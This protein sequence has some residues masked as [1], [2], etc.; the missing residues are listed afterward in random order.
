VQGDRS[1]PTPAGHARHE[2]PPWPRVQSR[3]QP[4]GLLTVRRRRLTAC[5][6]PPVGAVQH[7]FAWFYVYGAVEP[8][9][10]ARFF[11]ARPDL[12]ADMFQR[13]IETFAQA[14]AD[15]LKI[16]LVDTRGAHTAQ[17]LTLPD[18]VPL[19]C[20]PPYGPE[21]NPI[22]RGWRDLKETLA[23]LHWAKLETQQDDMATLLRGYEAATRPTLTDYTYLVEAV[24]ALYP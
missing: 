13:F 11:L 24:H 17:R 9:T 4:C 15:S 7:R 21:R 23:W 22:A 5:G 20:V 3:R 8:T 14:F 6:V 18:H 2:Y 19:V 16:L 10:G 1:G 12:H